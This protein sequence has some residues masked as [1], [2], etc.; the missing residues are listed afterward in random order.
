MNRAAFRVAF[1]LTLVLG[2]PLSSQQSP[3]GD[4]TTFDAAS[5]RRNTSGD[6]YG[7]AGP[8]PGGRF[9]MVNL[10][11]L[12]LIRAAYSELNP[13]QIV[14]APEWVNTERYDVTATAGRNTSAAEMERMLRELLAERFKLRTRLESRDQ[15]AFA[16]VRA[17]ASGPPPPQLRQVRVDCITLIA[18]AGTSSTLPRSNNGAPPCGLIYDGRK[19]AAGG[20]TMAQLARNLTPLVGRPIVDRTGLDGHYEF[21]LEYATRE[22]NAAGIPATNDSRPSIV[23]ALQEQLGLRL[24]SRRMAVDV[25][26]IDS[27]ER[28]GPD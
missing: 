15:D 24:D 18:Q 11:V 17:T 3:G 27:V 12:R 16:L 10:P 19:L 28:P 22:G 1:G 26:I 6:A 21:T 23:V 9:V 13:S 7:T 25:L 5:V 8:Q 20:V 14:G 4:Q 2:I